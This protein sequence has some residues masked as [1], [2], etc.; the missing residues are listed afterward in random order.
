MRNSPEYGF[1][2]DR[3]LEEE[4]ALDREFKG[5]LSRLGF[6]FSLAKQTSTCPKPLVETIS[7]FPRHF[8]TVASLP[9]PE[10]AKVRRLGDLIVQSFRPGCQPFITVRLVGHA[11]NDPQQ[12]RLQPGFMMKISRERAASV[13]TALER[14]IQGKVPVGRVIFEII[15]KAA[16]EP[17]VRNAATEPE[18]Q[19]NRRVQ[20]TLSTVRPDP[21]INCAA[22]RGDQVDLAEAAAVHFVRTKLRRKTSPTLV[23]CWEPRDTVP[24]T[25]DVSFSDDIVVQV[26]VSANTVRAIVSQADKEPDL[27]RRGPVAKYE[28]KCLQSGRFTFREV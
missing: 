19:R 8:N 24:Y 9:G 4:Q 3:E 14:I 11:D 10:Q 5:N 17:I 6:R 28:Y 18:R 7:Q 27:V 1:L 22:A 20:V 26:E 21:E 16:T 25:C 15:G 13:K 12:E 23:D 2:I